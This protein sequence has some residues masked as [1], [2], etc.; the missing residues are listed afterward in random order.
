MAQNQEEKKKLKLWDAIISFF[1]KA[2]LILLGSPEEVSNML[3]LL[4]FWRAAYMNLFKRTVACI[5]YCL[6]V[7]AVV[8][9]LISF[10]PTSK[11]PSLFFISDVLQTIHSF[12]IWISPDPFLLLII[13]SFFLA[14]NGNTK[15]KMINDIKRVEYLISEMKKDCDKLLSHEEKKVSYAKAVVE[16]IEKYGDFNTDKFPK[17]PEQRLG[18]QLQ[19]LSDQIETNTYFIRMN[20]ESN[21]EKIENIISKYVGRRFPTRKLVLGRSI[22]NCNIPIWIYIDNIRFVADLLLGDEIENAKES[23][24]EF[25]GSVT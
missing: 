17:T 4:P 22:S 5:F 2:N 8:N 21:V 25:I 7:T 3:S 20:I 11:H 6:L 15:I 19:K 12:L 16:H 23:R 13:L 14:L 1:P 9:T 10:V 18:L 24:D